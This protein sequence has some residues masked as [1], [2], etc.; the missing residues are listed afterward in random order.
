MP[1]SVRM[2]GMKYHTALAIAVTIACTMRVLG[3]ASEPLFIAPLYVE[4]TT[5]T[6][7]EFEEQVGQLKQRIGQSTSRVQVGFSA[8]LGVQLDGAELDKPVDRRMAKPTL[9]N[10]DLIVERARSNQIPIHISIISNSFHGFDAFRAMAIAADVRNAQW[11][12]DG[13]IAPP[14]EIQQNAGVPRSAWITPSRNA[15]ALR[16]RMQETAAIV[17]DRLAQAMEQFPDVLLSISG[18]SEVEFSYVRTLGSEGDRR[19][20]DGKIFYADYSPFMVAEFRDSLRA[21]Y[22]GDASPD[23]DDDHDG[24]TFNRD[25]RRRFRTWQLRYFDDSGPIPFE[26][27]R[28]MTAK[29]P[30]SAPYFIDGGFDAPRTPAAQD[31]LWQAWK[32]FRIHAIENYLHDYATW[33]A[34]NSRIPASRFYTHQIPADFVFAGRDTTRLETSASPLETAF[35]PG[36]VSAG[37]TVFDTF[38]GKAHT[39]TSSPAMFRRLEQSS[40]HWGILEYNPSVPAVGDEAFY[41]RTLRSLESFHPTIIAPFAWTDAAQHKQYRIQ[42]T[43][44]ERALKKFTGEIQR[45]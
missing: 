11:Y 32:K 24:H 38:N 34:G 18:D 10:I 45:R 22:S 44:F 19:N 13:S 27:Y 1:R 25:F 23:S 6:T 15:Q 28:S 5:S 2:V 20:T 35:L 43:A 21:R 3:R 36:L 14:D 9:D 33:I 8:F 7:A 39:K 4:Y 30:E 40:D 41:L 37:V 26:Q 12:A 17:G 16:K 29:L 31:P 42:D